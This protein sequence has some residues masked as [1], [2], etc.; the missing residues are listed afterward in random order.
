MDTIRVEIFF[1]V[2]FSMKKFLFLLSS[3]LLIGGTT[4]A[5]FPGLFPDTANFARVPIW[6]G[7]IGKVL[8]ILLGTND[9][10]NYGG[11]GTVPDSRALSWVSA[12]GYLK[13]DLNCPG[14]Q[15]FTGIDSDGKR[16]CGITSTL[17]T[18][19]GKIFSQDCPA[20]YYRMDDTQGTT[21]TGDVLKAWDIVKTPPGCTMTIVFADFSLLRLDGDTTI[22]LD[23]WTLADGSTIAS[24]IL[25]N[26]SVWWRIL[27]ET[28]SYNVGTDII[29][30]WVRGTSISVSS[31]GNTISITNTWSGWGITRVPGPSHTLVNLVDSRFSSGA[32]VFCK[33]KV[34]SLIESLTNMWI[35]DTYMINPLWCDLIKPT[36]VSVVKHQNFGNAWVRR[37]TRNDIKYMYDLRSLSGTTLSAVKNTLIFD[38]L[39]VTMPESNVA[40][41]LTAT[42]L[43]ESTTI[44]EPGYKWWNIRVGCQDA[45]IL[46]IADFTRPVPESVWQ[47]APLVFYGDPP[48]IEPTLWAVTIPDAGTWV[49]IPD[50][51]FISYN[52]STLALKLWWSFNGRKIIVE[53]SSGVIANKYILFFGGTGKAKTRSIPLPWGKHDCTIDGWSCILKDISP[54]GTRDLWEITISTWTPWDFNVWGT[55]ASTT[56]IE[57]RINS[58]IIK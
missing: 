26:G 38:E 52:V 41:V 37:N 8:T 18:D 9:L 20:D 31:T 32:T 24:A 40:W 34:T 49:N 54:G 15:K 3:F 14:T 25:S 10:A 45:S 39:K 30:V 23:L 28:G 21:S 43:L 57:K 48:V 56:S 7:T 4:F 13:D 53:T 12:S 42:W 22:S 36:A 27:T 19:Y 17:L 5:L 2:N 44:C 16:I 33:N 46:A 47:L 6:D 35:G 11:D 50:T 55:A 29:V 1:V 58:I 51:Q